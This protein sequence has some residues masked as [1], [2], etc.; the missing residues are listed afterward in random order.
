MLFALA[1]PL[2][3]ALLAPFTFAFPAPFA[4]ALPL[5]VFDPSPRWLPRWWGG[6][7]VLPWLRIA[8]AGGPP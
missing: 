6:R 3:F 7:W 2:P 1:L 8:Q 5:P 4:F